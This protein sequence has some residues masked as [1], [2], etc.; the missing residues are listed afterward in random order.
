[1]KLKP[2]S[3][4]TGW[5]TLGRLLLM[6]MLVMIG[7]IGFLTALF[8]GPLIYGFRAGYELVES[9]AEA[10]SERTRKEYGGQKD[11]RNA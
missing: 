2:T 7:S 9:Y 11:S 1:M 10:T 5:Q 6:F 4:L 3:E 8:I